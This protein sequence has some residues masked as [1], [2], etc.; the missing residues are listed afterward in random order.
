MTSLTLLT[1]GAYRQGKSLLANVFHGR[2]DGFALGAEVYG[3]TRGIWMWDTPFLHVGKRV[4]VLDCEGIDDPEQDHEWATKLFILCLAISSTFIYNLRGT[5]GASDIGKLFLMENLKKYIVPPEGSKFMP[6][7][8][9][10]L[11]D[12]QHKPPDDFQKYFLKQL[13]RTNAEGK[14]IIDFYEI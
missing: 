6:H 3:K 1:V 8:V 11:R 13:A 12:F 9:V 14:Y 7:L 5:V 10:L 4:V 2:L